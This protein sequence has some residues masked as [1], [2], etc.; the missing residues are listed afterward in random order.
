MYVKPLKCPGAR[1]ECVFALG[2]FGD[3]DWAVECADTAV[4]LGR[5][6]FCVVCEPE[7]ELGGGCA[8]GEV[9]FYA[10]FGIDGGAVMFGYCVS[11]VH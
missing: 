7:V 10:V 8:H 2:I 1:G 4:A 6:V 3:G 11:T 9:V 5:E